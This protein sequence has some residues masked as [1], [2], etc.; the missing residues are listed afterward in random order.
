[1]NILTLEN[2]TVSLNDLPDTMDTDI[3]ISILD[4]RN[5]NA[6]DFTFEPL[7]F[8]ETYNAPAVVLRVGN[9]EIHLPADWK[10]AIG[11][12]ITGNDLEILPVTTIYK[13][14]FEAFVYN[15]LVSFRPE[16]SIIEMVNI[17]H[18]VKWY[19]PRLN[20]NQLIATPLTNTDAP[21]C[22]FAGQNITKQGEQINYT[23]LL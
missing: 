4:N 3:H 22:V 21:L 16:F 8:L 13:R 19:V 1:M 11:D 20:N 14:G 17:Y 18:D 7:M 23:E 10:I 15:P 5:Y 2:K 9:Q 6:P 12:S